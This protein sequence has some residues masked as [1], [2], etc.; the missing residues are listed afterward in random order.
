M[1]A[2]VGV[3]LWTPSHYEMASSSA[4]TVDHPQ[5]GPAA[6]THGEESAIDKLTHIGLDVHKNTIV[7]AVLRYGGVECDE[8]VIPNIPRRSADS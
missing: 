5:D 8:R 4:Y 6:P 7:L 2:P 1:N 3:G